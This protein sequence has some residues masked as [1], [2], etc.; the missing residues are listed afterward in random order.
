MQR[1]NG[2]ADAFR[3]A[4]RFV[5]G[6]FYNYHCSKKNYK[7]KPYQV[8]LYIAACAYYYLTHGRDTQSKR[9]VFLSRISY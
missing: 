2:G 1:K 3:K 6:P 7:S 9:I 8:I 5:D 4:D